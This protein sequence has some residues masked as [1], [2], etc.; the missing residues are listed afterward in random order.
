[1]FG[2]IRRPA[3]SVPP[4]LLPAASRGADCARDGPR[5]RRTALASSIVE[6]CS[7]VSLR[8]QGRPRRRGR[9]SRDSTAGRLP[10][11]ARGFTSGRRWGTDRRSCCCT[12]NRRCTPSGTTSPPAA[13]TGRS[14]VWGRRASSAPAWTR[15]GRGAGASLAP[16]ARPS[17]RGTSWSRSRA[18]TWRCCSKPAWPRSTEPPRR[19]S[20]AAESST[21]RST[22]STLPPA[23][24]A[25]SPADQPRSASASKS[26]GYELTSPIPAGTSLAPS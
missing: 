6:I 9:C 17:R 21:S 26:R 1:M 15:C 20:L 13:D 24:L 8:R 5:R 18:R 14:V 19:Q 7:D 12:G 11:A 16:P 10:S 23:S 3:D 22:R 25:R 2:L 4:Q